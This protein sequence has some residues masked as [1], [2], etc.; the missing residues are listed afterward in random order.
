MIELSNVSFR[1]EGTESDALAGIDLTV[2]TGECFVLTGSSGCG[3]TTV[4]RLINGL[5]PHFYAGEVKGS[6]KIDG[7]DCTDREPHE[8]AEK[9]GSVF[10]NPRTQFFNSDTDSEIVFG[11]EN[12]AVPYDEM[13]RRY[14]DTIAILELEKLCGKD[15]FSL[16]G[17]EKQSIAFG[18]VYALSPDIYVLDEPSA[19]LDREAVGRLRSVLLLLKQRGKTILVS[20]HRLYYLKDIADRIVLIEN[21]HIAG[22]HKA[23]VLAGRPAEQL[24]RLGLRSFKDTE[25]IA[26]SVNAADGKPPALEIRD[27]CIQRGKTTVLRGVNMTVGYGEIVGITGQNGIGKTTLAR[28]VC[29]LMKEKSGEIR[30]HGSP[31]KAK[32]RKQH[33]FLVMQD[34]NYQLFSD[35]VETELEL[36]VSG[37]RPDPEQTRQLLKELD[38]DSVR[39]KHP[40]AL[41][42]GQKQRVC[43]ALAA[44]SHADVLLFD[45]PTSG[46]DYRNMKRVSDML[47]ILAGRG[48]AVVVISHDNEFLMEACTR[49]IPLS[50]SKSCR[51][52]PNGYADIPARPVVRGNEAKK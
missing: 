21:G 52:P 19:N 15:I 41:S 32:K 31:I 13:H 50:K 4:T 40:L 44:L 22:I 20:E 39:E 16:S 43:I 14:D 25:I 27:V 42:G 2:S 6:V 10:Q 28:T 12:C 23:D 51:Q 45:E 1:Y 18:S 37:K 26:D 8:L 33:V 29:G 9:A 47:R 38:L 49:M 5:I 36:T 7:I 24:H 48:K 11:M 3:K 17:G 35:S 34:P 46:L 30:F